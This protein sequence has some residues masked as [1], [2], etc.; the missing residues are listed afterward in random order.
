LRKPFIGAAQIM[1]NF[2][3]GHLSDMDLIL[4]RHECIKKTP[5]EDKEFITAINFELSKREK[6]K[7]RA[8]SAESQP[9][10]I[11]QA[12]LCDGAAPKPC[13]E[14]CKHFESETCMRCSNYWKLQFEP[15]TAS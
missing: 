4:M 5:N 9:A 15:R 6:Q 11:Q 8:A 2:E 1:N 14:L 10:I 13:A 7:P 3:F 12:A